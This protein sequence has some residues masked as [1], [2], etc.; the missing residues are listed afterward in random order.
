MGGLR[1]N[2]ENKKSVRNLTILNSVAEASVLKLNRMVLAMLIG[3]MAVVIVMGALLMPEK[4]TFNQV[5]QA[6]DPVELYEVQMNPVLSAEVDALKSQLVTLVSGSI[7]SK[8][9]TLED[10]LR[11]GTI[12]KTGLNTIRAL[13]EDLVVLKTYSET[14][15]GRLIAQ[16]YLAQPKN[17]ESIAL[18][19]QVSQLKSLVYFLITSCGLMVAVVGGVWVRKRYALEN[20]ASEQKKIS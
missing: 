14:G 18:A 17:L 8:L 20:H 2:N 13:Q 4:Y 16:K 9:K 10:A 6:V 3:L 5:V 11:N 1:K 19:E 15:T 12:T 7:E